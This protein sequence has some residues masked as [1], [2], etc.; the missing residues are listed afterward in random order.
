I[1]VGLNDARAGSCFQGA[2][3]LRGSIGNEL[4]DVGEADVLFWMHKI[5]DQK[6]RPGISG[7]CIRDHVCVVGINGKITPRHVDA[8]DVLHYFFDPV[9]HRLP[10]SNIKIRLLLFLRKDV[11]FSFTGLSD[12][13]APLCPGRVSSSLLS[14]KPA[15][16]VLLIG[17]GL[18]TSA[19]GTVHARYSGIPAVRCKAFPTSNPARRP[20]HSE[21][22][23]APWGSHRPA[24]RVLRDDTRSLRLWFLFCSEQS[25]PARPSM[26]RAPDAFR[27]PG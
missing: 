21:C 7:T 24:T 16:C 17:V 12:R 25:E 18:A 26:F 15:R 22:S 27:K 2:I 9:D 19:P 10:N 20:V 4:L 11:R 1:F 14:S 3:G 6:A 23:Q 13:S 8:Q 5:G